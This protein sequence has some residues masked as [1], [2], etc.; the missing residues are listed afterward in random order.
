[1]RLMFLAALCVIVAAPGHAA[2]P[3]NGAKLAQQCAVCHGINGLAKQPD[4]PNLA[5]ESSIYITQQLKAFRSGERQ[6]PQM[7]VMAGGLSDEHIA[8]LA[9][10]YDALEVSVTVPD[11]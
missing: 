6:N 5:G 1:M 11:F 9:A 10:Y 7:S 3:A 4:V 2:D 8:D